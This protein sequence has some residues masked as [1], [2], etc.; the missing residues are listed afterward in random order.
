MKKSRVIMNVPAKTT[1]SGPNL[2]TILTGRPLTLSSPSHAPASARLSRTP[3]KGK[4]FVSQRIQIWDVRTTRE[5]RCEIQYANGRAFGH[6]QRVCTVVGASLRHLAVGR[7]FHDV[8]VG[9]SRPAELGRPHG[10]RDRSGR[11]VAG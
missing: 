2:P 5:P 1:G 3:R 8:N 7:G 10:G 11:R 4:G 9:A 6:D